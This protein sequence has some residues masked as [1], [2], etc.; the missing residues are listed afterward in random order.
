MQ[1][2]IGLR[3]MLKHEAQI[4]KCKKEKKAKKEKERGKNYVT[5]V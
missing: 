1:Q 5:K 3:Q 2:G 4:N